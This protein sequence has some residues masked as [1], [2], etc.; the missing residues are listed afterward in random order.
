VYEVDCRRCDGVAATFESAFDAGYHDQHP[1]TCES[2]GVRG[3]IDVDGDEDGAH[4]AFIANERE[5]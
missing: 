1:W 4:V 5:I 3:K 2:C